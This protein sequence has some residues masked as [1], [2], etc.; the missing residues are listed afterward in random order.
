[1]VVNECPVAV[2][3]DEE[4]GLSSYT[5][6]K[7]AG[8]DTIASVIDE[9]RVTYKIMS[10]NFNPKEYSQNGRTTTV[11]RKRFTTDLMSNFVQSMKFTIVEN[12]L[13]FFDNWFIDLRD[14]T[15]FIKSYIDGSD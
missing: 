1:M 3:A 2:A 13:R 4:S 12:S 9:M 6:I 8:D 11:M 15:F 14:F 7:C 10:Q 5:D